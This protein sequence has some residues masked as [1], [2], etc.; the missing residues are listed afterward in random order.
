MP[1]SNA[2]D[3]AFAGICLPPSRGQAW[4]KNVDIVEFFIFYEIL[5]SRGPVLV[6]PSGGQMTAGGSP[7]PEFDWNVD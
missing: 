6:M 4:P 2:S 1:G 3:A 7:K 5:R